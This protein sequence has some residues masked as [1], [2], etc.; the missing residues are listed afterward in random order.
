MKDKTDRKTGRYDESI[1]VP[2]SAIWLRYPKK[3]HLSVCIVH[4]SGDE[5]GSVYD[6]VVILGS[7]EVKSEG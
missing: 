5:R 4:K 6:G 1:R 2:F 3:G 7:K